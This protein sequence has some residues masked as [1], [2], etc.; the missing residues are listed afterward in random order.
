MLILYTLKKI[1]QSNN[2]QQNVIQIHSLSLIFIL[3]IFLSNT[4]AGEA[5]S[6]V[7]LPGL[8]NNFQAIVAGNPLP[9]V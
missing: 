4:I 5:T 3:Q 1:Y 2:V 7:L 8:Y 6:S 9:T